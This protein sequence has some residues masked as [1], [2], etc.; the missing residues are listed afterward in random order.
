MRRLS[1][2]VDRFRFVRP[3]CERVSSRHRRAWACGWCVEIDSRAKDGF[4]PRVS[5]HP[6]TAHACTWA[7]YIVFLGTP[8]LNLDRRWGQHTLAGHSTNTLGRRLHTSRRPVISAVVGA[9]MFGWGRV[10]RTAAKAAAAA[11]FTCQCASFNI[12]QYVCVA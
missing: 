8:V 11:C 12:A 5:A 3:P 10:M 7:F 9:K 6:Q 1:A 2:T 4:C